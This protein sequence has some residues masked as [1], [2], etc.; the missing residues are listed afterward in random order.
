MYAASYHVSPLVL[1]DLVRVETGAVRNEYRKREGYPGIPARISLA[2]C[3]TTWYISGMVSLP[4]LVDL[5]GGT[6]ATH[7]HRRR[8]VRVFG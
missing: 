7:P 3:R 6:C 5:F 4:S 2:G 1:R 8:S